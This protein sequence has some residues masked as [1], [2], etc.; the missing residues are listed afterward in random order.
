MGVYK[1]CTRPYLSPKRHH[2]AGTYAY[3]SLGSISGLVNMR[4]TF[5]RREQDALT[6]VVSGTVGTHIQGTP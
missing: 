4:K 2:Y 3:C 1:P 6:N 5:L